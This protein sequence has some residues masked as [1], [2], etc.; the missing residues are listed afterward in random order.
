MKS[1]GRNHANRAN[2]DES[3]TDRIRHIVAIDFRARSPIDCRNIAAP[4][5][6]TFESSH[7]GT[8]HISADYSSEKKGKAIVTGLPVHREDVS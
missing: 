6:A 2:D 8:A 4:S 1:Q 5:T 3:T 7:P